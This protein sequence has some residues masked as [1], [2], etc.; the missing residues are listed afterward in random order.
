MCVFRLN[1]LN[2]VYTKCY[3]KDPVQ[4]ATN[5]IEYGNNKIIVYESDLSL[6]PET[7]PCVILC[8]H[9]YG[10]LDALILLKT[11]VEKRPDVRFIANFL[12]SRIEPAAHL[13]MQVN[14]FELRK[15]AFSSH[16][17]LKE[18]YK[19]IESGGVV[20]ILP[21]GEVS[22]RYGKSKI[23]EDREW[24]ANMMKYVKSVGVPVISAFISGQNSWLFHFLG[25]FNPALR[26]AL[27]PHELLNKRNKEIVFRLSNPAPS[28]FIKSIEDDKELANLLRAKTYCLESVAQ[29]CCDEHNPV[30]YKDVVAAGD[31]ELLKSEIEKICEKDLL[32][33][34]DNYQVFFSIKQ[35]IP[36]IFKELSRLREITFREIGEGTGNELDTDKFDDYYHHLFIWDDAAS[37][38][39]GAYRIGMGAEIIEEKGVKGFYINS[40]F[41]FKDGFVPYLSKSMEMGRSFIV[42][43]YQRK[44]LP[45]FLLW[46]GIYFV[47]QR[48]SEYRYLIGPA[49]IS[50][51]YS[52]NAK[53]LMIEFLKRHHSWPELEET[54]GSNIAFDYTVNHHHEVVLNSLG[55]NLSAMDRFIRDIDINHFGIPVLIKKYLSLGG[56]ILEF[57]VD[58]DFNFAIDG[59]IILDIDVVSEEVIKSYNK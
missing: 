2:R 38:L 17:G 58:P 8:N 47:T 31:A 1:K 28:K 48:F 29:E 5:T 50:S 33:T 41:S 55:T 30:V 14:P 34:T 39:V 35:D 54:V 19:V 20:C 53:V 42:A 15:Q 6:I 12:L 37:A 4:F 10:G 24:Q 43:E 56:K 3:D 25:K 36:N 59:F 52:H 9:P 45:L 22:T 18:M 27:L 26:T 21:S 40:L 11:L 16:A 44:T 51:L 49:S 13:L 7:G 32:F 23:V 46:K 57:N